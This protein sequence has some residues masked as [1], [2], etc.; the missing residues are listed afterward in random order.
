MVGDTA[1]AVNRNTDRECHQ[2]LCFYIERFGSG[3]R[4]RKRAKGPC[5]IWR[6][7]PQ[8]PDPVYYVVATCEYP[9]SHHLLPS[10]TVPKPQA[11]SYALLGTENMSASWAAAAVATIRHALGHLRVR[12]ER[13]CDHRS[14]AEQHIDADDQSQRSGDGAWQTHQD[15]G[16]QK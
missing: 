9:C 8:E 16:G 12:S 10:M 5:R 6:T 13:H 11:R 14:P 4:N 3:R 2:F 1:A 15:Q 7:L